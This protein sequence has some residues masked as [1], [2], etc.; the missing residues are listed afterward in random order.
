MKKIHWIVLLAMIVFVV[1]GEVIKKANSATGNNE[2]WF[3][4]KSTGTAGITGIN[5]TNMSREI[6]VI[7]KSTIPCY[8]NWTDSITCN[9]TMFMLQRQAVTAPPDIRTE[10]I[11]SSRMSIYQTTG[12]VNIL[13]QNKWN[14]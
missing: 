7:N 1:A 12:P 4:V 3:S 10:E 14:Q 6:T 9:N 8:V 11:R 5:F 13:I 2:E